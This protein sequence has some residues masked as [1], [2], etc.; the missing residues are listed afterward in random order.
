[1]DHLQHISGN[2]QVSDSA[3]LAVACVRN[4]AL[5]L[6]DFLA[7]HRRLGVDR[8]FIVDNASEDG[9]AAYLE[10]QP[11]VCLFHT[12]APYSTSNCGIDW[13]NDVLLAHAVGHWTLILDA[14]ELFVFPGYETIPLAD[15]L[16]WAES[17]RADAVAA[18]MLDMYPE[19]P[20]NALEYLPGDR[21]ID[22][23]PMFDGSGYNTLRVGPRHRV[24]NRGGPRARLFWDER[25]LGYPPPMLF[26]IP[27]IKW[28]AAR[29]LTASTHNLTGARL[30][31]A[32]GLLL[33]FKFLQ[34][35]AA[36]AAQEAMRKEHFMGAR[37]YDA[38]NA[39]LSTVSDFTAAFE[40]SIRYRDSWQLVEME[41]MRVPRRSSFWSTA[42]R[43][44]ATQGRN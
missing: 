20:L 4:E 16:S 26:K 44:Y 25:D 33:H 12:S 40:G 23:C 6:P 38:Y 32:N 42:I 43:A 19:G 35:F 24:I 18:P 28:T 34:D 14:D 41:L 39:V 37:Q 5:R 36:E 3:I 21:L 2:P 13:L 29:K 1:M 17:R 7:H 31:P 22:A 15:F 9:S 27:L 10:S 8:F 11:D 30:A